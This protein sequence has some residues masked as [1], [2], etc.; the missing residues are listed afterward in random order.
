LAQRD[1]FDSATLEV[2]WATLRGPAD[3]SWLSLTERSGWLRLRGRESYHSLFRQSLVAKRLQQF[4]A[5]AETCL[6]FAPTHYTQMAGLIF[7]Y[8]TRTHYYLRVTHHETRGV[9]LGIVLTDDGVY[10]ELGDLEVGDWPRFYLRAII[11]RTTVQF[12]ASPEGETWQDI[13]PALDATKLSDD[14]GQGLHFTGAMIGLCAQ[15]LGG[16]RQS[17]ADFDYFELK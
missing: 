12:S 8:D 17:V 10:D 5:T 4:T 3:E 16:T 15:D 13:G 11:D 9:I 1:P 7:Y 6:E 2:N 14:Y